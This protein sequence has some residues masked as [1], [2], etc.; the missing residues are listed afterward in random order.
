[1]KLS[2]CL[3]LLFTENSPAWGDRVRAARAAGCDGI[4]FW[5]WRDKPLGEIR[6]AATDSG[7]L[8][9][10]MAVEPSYQLTDPNL[11]DPFVA[12]VAA[13]CEAAARVGCRNLVA[14]AGDERPMA[15]A[16]AQDSA[17]VKALRAAAPVAGHYGVTLL[18]EP[19]NKRAEP[20]TYLSST[21]R[22]IGLI[23]RVA[24]PEVRLLYDVYHSAMDGEEPA[25]QMGRAGGLIGHV[26]VADTDG[27]HEPGT[28]GI[29]W[30]RTIRG[31]RDTG[32]D[33]HLGL[34]YLPA[35]GSLDSMRYLR[36]ILAAAGC[37]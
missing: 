3:E 2:A 31:L 19:L 23:E 9:V 30:L 37:P 29:D 34:E 6:E 35:A 13:S 22:A 32:Y 5:T 33:G 1:M 36:G 26:Q 4:E 10:S 8:V 7:V 24:R 21:R 15:S 11:R 25:R 28:G 20:S 18:L 14:L 17:I 16:R 27:R 12:A